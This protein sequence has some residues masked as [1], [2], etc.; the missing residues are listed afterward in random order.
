MTDRIRVNYPA[1]EE[2]ASH[3]DQVAERTEDIV[4]TVGKMGQQLMDSAMIGDTGD[5]VGSAIQGPFTASS[6]R[7]VMKFREVSRDIR[8]AIADMRAAD[9]DAGAGF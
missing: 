6:M 3:F 2:M 8:A 4:R 1:L 9:R 5:A 7:L